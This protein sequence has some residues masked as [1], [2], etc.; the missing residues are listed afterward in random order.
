M[1]CGS[2]SVASAFAD[3]TAQPGPLVPVRNG[4]QLLLAILGAVLLGGCVHNERYPE[5]WEPVQVGTT[6]DCAA[7]VATYANEGENGNGSRI[8]LTL[9][10]EPRQYKSITNA[11]QAA[12]ESDLTKAQTVQLQLTANVL[13]ITASGKNIH[14]EWSFDSNKRE[15][16]CN[17]GVVRI[18]RFEVANDIVLGVSKGS[19]YLYRVGDHLVLESK[20]VAVGLALLIVPVAGGGTSWARFAVIPS[21]GVP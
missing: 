21:L 14:R 8:A 13:T 9:W 2:L 19:D 18:H 20:G 11:E 7:V 3:W 12:Y 5:S 10:L 16:D 15:F 4:P 6:T 1:S 17:H